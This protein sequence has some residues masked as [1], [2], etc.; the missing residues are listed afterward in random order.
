META[1]QYGAFGVAGALAILALASPENPELWLGAWLAAAWFAA[2]GVTTRSTRHGLGAFAALAFACSAYLFWRKLDATGTSFCSVSA[3][4]DCDLVNTSAASEL[5][6]IPISLLGMGY[7]GGLAAAAALSSAPQQRL[8]QLSGLTSAVG[9]VYCIYLFAEATQLPAWCMLCLTIYAS[10]AAVFGASLVGA[11]EHTTPLLVD[12][13]LAAQSTSAQILGAVFLGVSVLGGM[14]FRSA[15]DDAPPPVEAPAEPGAPA[16]APDPA[17]RLLT[18]YA[19]PHGRMAL[20]GDEPVLGDPNAPYVVVEYAC[21]GCPH[22]AEALVHLQELVA[23]DPQ[24]QVRFRSF[25]LTGECNPLIQRGGAPEKCRAAM[26]AQCA[27]RQGKFWPFASY[28]FERQRSLGE[29]LLSEAAGEVGL[30]FGQFSSC[31]A[32]PGILEQVQRDA[33]SGG[34]MQIPGTPAMFL[35]GVAGDDWVEV[36]GG[37]ESVQVLVDAHQAG[38]QFLPAN[39][40]CPQ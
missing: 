32:D 22:C 12:V 36:C 13:P 35:R 26:A 16:A 8:Y 1:K 17:R 34:E 6:G 11:K 9:L 5:F 33:L 21:F 31:M 37:A 25:P 29:E 27:N 30:D 18:F 39:A 28:V 15:S 2:L 10:T 20:E 40:E 24:I 38:V 7:F 14:A 19:K 3:T 23:K 4:F